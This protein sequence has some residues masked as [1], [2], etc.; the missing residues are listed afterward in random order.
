[1]DKGAHFYKCDLQ[2]HTPRD[3]VWSGADAVSDAERKAYANE[4]ILACRQKC[5]GAIAITDHHDFAF[6][7]YVKGAAQDELDDAG[8]PIP[9]GQRIVVFPGIEMT[10]TAPP[11]QA[12][13][14]LDA[15]FPEN[16][17]PSVLTALAITPAPSA[18]SKHQPTVQ[19]IPQSV[20]SGLA[21]L[22]EKL[23]A[24]EYLRGRFAV[25]PNVT[26][27]GH[28]TM[29]RSG[30]ADFYRTM[31]CVGGYT[32]GP[33]NFGTGNLA[34]VQGRNRE[35]G[36]KSI[37]VFQTSDNRKRDHSDLGKHTTWIKWSEPTAE[38]LRQACLA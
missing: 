35:Y 12:L 38:A 16:L 14:I 2:V 4:L 11:C 30:F 10:L 7:P 23:N 29:L 8:Q 28:G 3:T 34:I 21:D 5:L 24:H 27:G 19:R 33:I 37:G 15:D 32:D 13:L 9:A 6:F 26:D 36:F 18:D 1:M 22:Y 25:L 20:V 17:L 31:P